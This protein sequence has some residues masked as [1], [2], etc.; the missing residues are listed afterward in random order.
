MDN[1]SLKPNVMTKTYQ[2]LTS[3]FLTLTAALSSMS[4]ADTYTKNFPLKQPTKCDQLYLKRVKL[5]E[6]WNQTAEEGGIVLL[7]DSIT[8]AFPVKQV[9][10]EW[11]LQARGIAGDGIGG[12]KY[13][14]LLDRLDVSCNDLKPSKIFI[15]IGINDIPNDPNAENK[16]YIPKNVKIDSYR[17][18]VK[19]LQSKN[20]S[21]E[22]YLCSILPTRGKYTTRNDRILKLN[23]ELKSLAQRER[24]HYIDMHSAFLA[25]K[26]MHQALTRDGIHLNGTGYKVWIKE[27]EKIMEK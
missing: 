4:A 14:G 9:P 3:I 27:L 6:K 18:L 7:G 8:Q 22:I 26:E 20:R 19:K 10:A 1:P 23:K 16:N 2:R 21:A 24:V 17:E 5:F 12:W 13:R 11:K 15:K 25:D